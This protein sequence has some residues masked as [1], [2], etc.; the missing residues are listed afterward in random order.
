MIPLFLGLHAANLIVMSIVFVLGLGATSGPEHRPTD[1]YAYHLAMGL[2]AGLL[3]T[4][5]HLTVYT[6]FM[7]TSK[8][9]HAAADKAGLDLHRFVVPAQQRKKY[10]LRYAMA[11]IVLTM[12]TMFAG[13]GADPTVHPLWPAEAHLALA[14]ITILG[15][16]FCAVGEYR[17]IRQ[18]GR[19]MDDALAVVN[20]T[21]H[22][23]T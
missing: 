17:L 16:A 19:L 10:S 13:A 20:A 11:A 8:W 1:L 12:V 2:A 14:A 23:A 5:A 9:L 18:Q 4:L 21:A 22:A 6:Y 3:T 15:N 7:G